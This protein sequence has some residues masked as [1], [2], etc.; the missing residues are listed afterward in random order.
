MIGAKRFMRVAS[1][2]LTAGVVMGLIGCGPTPPI[3]AFTSDNVVQQELSRAVQ[4]GMPREELARTLD[5][6]GFKRG[7]QVWREEPPGVLARAWPPGGFWTREALDVVRYTD[8][9]GVLDAEG[10]LVSWSTQRGTLVYRYGEP[11]SPGQDPRRNFPLPPLPPEEWR[12]PNINKEVGAEAWG[13]KTTDV[14]SGGGK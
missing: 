13:T 2:A 11:A 3:N 12:G 14:P 1:A 10:R 8:F 9:V 7:W 6:L 4:P 5:S